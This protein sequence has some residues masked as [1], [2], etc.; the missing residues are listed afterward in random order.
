MTKIIRTQAEIPEADTPTL[1]ATYNAMTGKSVKKFASRAAAET[2]TAMAILA[3]EDAAAHLGVSKGGKPRA[4]TAEEVAAKL[5]AIKGSPRQLARA[6]ESEDFSGPNPHK[7]G[8]PAY[9]LWLAG[10]DA[11]A[12]KTAERGRAPRI[13]RVRATDSGATRLHPASKRAEV[14]M[15]VSAR[16]SVGKRPAIPLSDIQAAVGP[17]ARGAVQKLITTGH[18]VAVEE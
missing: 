9:D 7:K 12:A 1:L 4:M 2:Q 6:V 13:T 11:K 10:R 14:M 18:L 8:T 15:L 16:G 17:N 3:A 5:A